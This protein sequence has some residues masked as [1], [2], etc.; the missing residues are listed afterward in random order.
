MKKTLAYLVLVVLFAV[1]SA[2]AAPDYQEG[3]WEIT[4]TTDMP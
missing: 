4:T 2:F 3:L 1:P